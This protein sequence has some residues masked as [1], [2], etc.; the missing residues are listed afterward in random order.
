MS[1]AAVTPAPPKGA[2]IRFIDEVGHFFVHAAP[3]VEEAAVAVEP[4]LALTPFGPEY[5]LVVNAIVGVQKTAAASLA[6]SAALTNEQKLS[7]V[8]QAITP[9]VTSVLAS[10]G[11]TEP[12]AVTAAIAQFAQNVYNFQAGPVVVKP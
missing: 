11:I 4:L 8:I 12:V 6:T 5:D 10:K 3:V 2:F 9:G 7:L 1:T